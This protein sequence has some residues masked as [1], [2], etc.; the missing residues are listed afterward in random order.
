MIIIDQYSSLFT[1]QLISTI[2]IIIIIIIIIIIN[3]DIISDISIIYTNII[4]MVY[5]LY[6]T[7]SIINPHGPPNNDNHI[8]IAINAIIIIHN[9]SNSTSNKHNSH[10]DNS[11]SYKSNGIALVEHS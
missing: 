7:I 10:I 11:T 2:Y 9:N 1:L 5:I 4:L 8:D 3:N 6:Y